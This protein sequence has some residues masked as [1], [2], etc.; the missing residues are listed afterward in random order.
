MSKM[1]YI[2]INSLFL[3]CFGG[4]SCNAFI[5]HAT[6]LPGSHSTGSMFMGVMERSFRSTFVRS[7]TDVQPAL[8]T[9]SA[10]IHLKAFYQAEVRT[11]WRPVTVSHTKLAHPCLFW[12]VG[13]GRGH[14]QI[15]QIVLVCWRVSS[16]GNKGENPTPEEPPDNTLL[17]TSNRFILY[18]ARR[19]SMN[20]DSRKHICTALEPSGGMLYITASDALH[21]AQ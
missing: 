4:I 3:S 17:V 2:C 13:T 1:P 14:R 20:C 7:D 15:V 21:C 10:L 6:T 12:H 8:L 11:L 19:R 5:T 9:V 18:I 16:T